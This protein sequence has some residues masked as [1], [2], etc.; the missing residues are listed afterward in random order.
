MPEMDGLE[1]TRRIRNVQSSVINH[2]VHI[3]ALTANAMQGDRETCLQA[4][5]NDYIEKPI[6]PA[7]LQKMLEKWLPSFPSQLHQKRNCRCSTG[8]A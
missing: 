3:I 7:K 6:S 1:T 2:A 8:R 5:M 4:G